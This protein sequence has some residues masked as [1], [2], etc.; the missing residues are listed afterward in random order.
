MLR[1][2]RI[3]YSNWLSGILKIISHSL[4]NLYKIYSQIYELN[5]RSC[6]SVIKSTQSCSIYSTFT[7]NRLNFPL[8]SSQQSWFRSL[9][10]LSKRNHFASLQ[11]R[12]FLLEI[13]SKSETFDFG[14]MLLHI[15]ELVFESS[16]LH[17]NL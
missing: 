9:Q 6:I 3:L 11:T 4:C 8:T 7:G 5:L 16:K 12:I 14:S 1:R 2:L 17:T 15:Y 13:I 10:F